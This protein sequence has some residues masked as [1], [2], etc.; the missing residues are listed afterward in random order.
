M[1]EKNKFVNKKSER[2]LQKSMRYNY[3][4]L[5]RRS[6]K[7]RRSSGSREG[8]LGDNADLDDIIAVRDD[9]FANMGYVDS[10]KM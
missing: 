6:R 7:S 9:E 4:T 3:D 10:M 8:N 2:I 1:Q 5:S